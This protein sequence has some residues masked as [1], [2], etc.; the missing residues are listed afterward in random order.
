MGTP[1]DNKSMSNPDLSD[2][3]DTSNVNVRKRKNRLDFDDMTSLQSDIREML[4]NFKADRDAQNTKLYAAIDD[5]KAQN[6][7]IIKTNSKIE[8]ILEDTT[9]LYNKLND[10]Y[11]KM[12]TEH[13]NAMIKINS[14]EEQVEAL[15]RA[16]SAAMVEIRNIPDTGNEDLSNLIAVMHG[17]LG[18]SFSPNNLKHVRRLKTAHK[19]QIIAEFQTVQQGTALLQAVKEYNKLHPDNKFNTLNLN[20]EGEKQLVYVSESLT[21]RARKL[22]Y[23]ARDLRKNHNYKHCWTRQGNVFVKQTDT[24]QPILIKSEQQIEALKAASVCQ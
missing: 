13:D 24:S 4:N 19:K 17:S 18:L 14:L 9:L 6:K 8:K 20:I 12:S 1:I 5:L 11:E 3:A 15:Q 2:N 22:H 21:P 16:Q 10:K 23:F 7:E